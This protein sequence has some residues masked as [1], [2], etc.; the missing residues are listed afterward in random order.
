VKQRIEAQIT[1]QLR[2]I[3]TKTLKET[4]FLMKTAGLFIAVTWSPP[5]PV[6]YHALLS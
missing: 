4:F 5:W 2:Q 1:V 3:E 6:T